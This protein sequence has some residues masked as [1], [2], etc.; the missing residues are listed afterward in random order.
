MKL[1]FFF[2]FHRRTGI[3]KCLRGGSRNIL[4]FFEDCLVLFDAHTHQFVAAVILVKNIASLLL[5]FFHVRSTL[6]KPRG[7]IPNKHLSQFDKVAVF[8]VVHFDDA[9]GILSRPDDPAV[10]GFDGSVTSDD[11]EGDFGHDFA[12]FG[13]CFVVI[14][15]IAGRL[16]NLD[17]MVC[18]IAQHLN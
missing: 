14:E 6:A 7:I 4:D 10:L 2:L 15:F 3:R 8:F 9:P 17:L 13:N 1:T 5:Q 16:E 12:V 18:N 11:R